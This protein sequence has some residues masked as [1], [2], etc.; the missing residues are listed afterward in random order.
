MTR[1]TWACAYALPEVVQVTYNFLPR[2]LLEVG[3]DA[4]AAALIDAADEYARRS[5][6][7]AIADTRG[8]ALLTP[9]AGRRA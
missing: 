1:S 6:V 9:A 5:G 7:A 8:L 4:E 2:G 3:R